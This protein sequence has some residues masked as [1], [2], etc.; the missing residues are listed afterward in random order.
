M[1][2]SILIFSIL[3]TTSSFAIT[4]QEK[5]KI[6]IDKILPAIEIV[7]DDL[8]KQY[9]VIEKSIKNNTNKNKIIALKR[10]YK[11]ES[12]EKL[13]LALKPHPKSIA[14]SQA[15]IESAWGTSRFF[16]KA[17]NIFGVWAFGKNT[18]RIAALK[19]RNGKTIWVKKYN[20]IEH[21]IRDYYLN[22]SR[23]FAF[24]E[25]REL[26]MKT[27]DPY[28]LVKE[29]KM[30]SEKREAY[31]KELASILKYNKFYKYDN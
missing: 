22:I 17:N 11:V 16:T 25:F 3:F 23:S 24:A 10:K 14:L 5:K 31:S 7:Y 9:D 18:P 8:Q 26:N 6:F 1:K 2:F 15:A 19:K 12:N 27:E 29:L 20:N 21:S 4:V 30:Y 28:L 13:L